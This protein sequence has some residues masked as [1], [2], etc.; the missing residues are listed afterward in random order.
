[1]G[2]VRAR[3]EVALRNPLGGAVLPANKAGEG[4]C[5]K[6]APFSLHQI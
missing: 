1:M 4:W 6:E 2:A 5:N 3:R